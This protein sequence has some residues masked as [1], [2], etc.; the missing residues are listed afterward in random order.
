MFDTSDFAANDGHGTCP[1]FRTGLVGRGIL[2]SGSP[3]LHEKEAAALGIRLRYSLFDFSDRNWSDDALGAVLAKALEL[4]F[5]GLNVTFPFKQA[6]IPLLDDLSDDARAIGAVNTVQM[7][8]GRLIGHNTDVTG[9]AAGFAEGLP[10]A[11]LDHVLQIGCGGAG[12]AIAHALLSHIGVGRLLLAD[13]DTVRRDALWRSL[14][15]R[16][17]EGR[18]AVAPDP[19]Q[20]ARGVSGIVNATPVGM[21]KF[22]GMPIPAAIIEPRHWI[23]DIVYFP[24]VTEFLA[25]AAAKGCRTLDGSSMVV[26]QAAGAF[27]IFLNRSADRQRMRRSFGEF[28]RTGEI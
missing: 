24:L 20:A 3:W 17:G 26:H 10:G 18:V 19:E 21:E 13:S 9:F 15:D 12:S 1:E 27:E 4:D 14:S 7:S 5:S 11:A 8:G 6:V 23:A 22:P 28:V 2:A 16:Y 25:Q